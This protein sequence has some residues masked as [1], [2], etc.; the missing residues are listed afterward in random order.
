MDVIFFTI[1]LVITSPYEQ[2]EKLG[3]FTH[4]DE[5]VTDFL[6]IWHLQLKLLNY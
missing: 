5:T 3:C 4:F 1:I 6:H 2:F